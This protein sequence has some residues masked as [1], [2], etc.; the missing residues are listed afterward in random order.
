M[1]GKRVFAIVPV[2]PLLEG[3]SRLSPI[4]DSKERQQL[5]T[6]LMQR[7]FDLIAAFPGVSQSIAISA[8]IEVAAEASAR[9]MIFVEDEARELNA[10]LAKAT[11]S[12][13][14]RGAQAIIVLPVDLPLATSA[15]LKR[16]VAEHDNADICVIVPDRRRTGTNLLYVSPPCDDLYRFGPN[17]SAL[18]REAAIARGFRT[19]D[20]EDPVL[21]LD[22]D[23][24][25]DYE[26][27][28]HSPASN[29]SRR[30]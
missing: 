23:E 9:G 30:A 20:I 21:S 1:A 22:I 27:W 28:R 3:K 13:I 2:K 15:D 25:E 17:S 18:H 10:A 7:T 16:I 26:R 4:M 19:L 24:P 11:R 6:F 12:A 29:P 8:D 5:N 14:A